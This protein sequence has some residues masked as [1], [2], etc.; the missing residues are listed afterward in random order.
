M[1]HGGVVFFLVYLAVF[2]LLGAPMLL[3]EMTLGQY[4]ALTPTKFYRNLCPALTGVGFAVLLVLLAQSMCDLAAVAWCA[5]A[6]YLLFSGRPGDAVPEDF[7]YREVLGFAP[8]GNAGDPGHPGD[9]DAGEDAG[10]GGGG[11]EL[12]SLHGQ[13]T[14]C[15]GVVCA[16]VFVVVSASTRSVGKVSMLLVP[17]SYGLLMTL[18]IR[19][20]LAPGGPDGVLTLLSP[21]WSHAGE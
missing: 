2:L 15:L 4:S 9:G 7:F 19:G 12:G 16:V 6:M 14:L 1:R 3:L 8:G 10:G 11:G 17:L 21:D 13:L 18:T 20:C 5:R